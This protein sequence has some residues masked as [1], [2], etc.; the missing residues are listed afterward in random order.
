MTIFPF[1]TQCSYNQDP[2]TPFYFFHF[3]LLLQFLET[4]LHCD[5]DQ[6]TDFSLSSYINPY[7]LHSNILGLPSSNLI[8][9]ISKIMVPSTENQ[10]QNR[11]LVQNMD[12]KPPALFSFFILSKL[13]INY[14]I[15]SRKRNF[16]NRSIENR[17][18][19]FQEYLVMKII[20]FKMDDVVMNDFQHIND[21]LG[22]QSVSRG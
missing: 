22:R 13:N 8:S 14:T 18:A 6:C 7:I 2:Q 3:L 1:Q 4:P 15:E 9:T 5:I 10:Y 21:E 20:N 11:L 12:M 17:T 19:T 16:L